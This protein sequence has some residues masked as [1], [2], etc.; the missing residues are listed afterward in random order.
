MTPEGQTPHKSL[1]STH[2]ETTEESQEVENYCQWSILAMISL[3]L[4]IVS[5]VAFLYVECLF[6][7]IVGVP[8]ALWAYFRIQ[9]S[10]GALLG[11]FAALIGLFFATFTLVG[12]SVL[13]SYY[14]YTVRMEA[15]RFFQIWFDAVKSQDIPLVFEMQNPVWYRRLGVAP[16][17]WW[18][19]KLTHNAERERENVNGFLTVLNDP[20]MKT[21]WVLGNQADISYYKTLFNCY[22]DGKDMVACLYAVTFM[23]PEQTDRETFFIK[24]SARRTRNPRDNTQRGWA[25]GAGGDSWAFPTVVREL[26]EELKRNR[27]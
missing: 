26:P 21:L 10:R 15:D 25:L 1:F 23:P 2:W 12:V 16:E 13:W 17:D 22:D 3:V 8:M 6:L 24:I 5:L 4:G 27:K 18:K 11:S 14:Q 7:A 20:C 9:R 19:S